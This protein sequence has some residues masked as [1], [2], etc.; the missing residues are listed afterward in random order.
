MATL[1]TQYKNYMYDN[2][3]SIYTFDEWRVKVL[4]ESLKQAIKKL[5]DEGQL[6]NTTFS[7][8]PKHYYSVE[9]LY[10]F[11]CCECKQWWSIGDY[12]PKKDK[13]L[14]CPACGFKSEVDVI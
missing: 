3:S 7:S 14:T 13:V 1:E 11:T 8:K 10:H 9:H 6:K 5:E 4:G 12:S 2:P